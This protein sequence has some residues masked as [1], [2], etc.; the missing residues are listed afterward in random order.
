MIGAIRAVARRLKPA[1][2]VWEGIYAHR[3]D[4]PTHRAEFTAELLDEMVTTTSR[5]LEQWRAGRK[6]LLWH[7]CLAV[8]AGAASAATRRVSVIDFG[9]G[10]GSAFV[11]LISSLPSTVDVDCVVVDSDEI[12]ARG[13][14]LF[15]NDGRIR[16]VTSLTA[17]PAQ[18][19]IIYLN[20]VLPY[21]DDYRQVLRQLA[22]LQPRFMLMARLT[23]G[24]VPTFAS[25][26]LNVPG[27]V[28][29]Y[30]FHNLPELIEILEG[31]GYVL[32]CHAY[33]EHQYDLSNFPATHRVGRLRNVL[34][35]R[36]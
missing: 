5:A 16:F 20:G 36:R 28:F 18:P 13:R 17:A 29:A 25:R 22:A 8:V 2:P 31:A 4:V 32:A 14:E 7:E 24:D 27:R 15:A 9:G 1:A 23:A 26:Q 30:W 19:D 21:I 33:A 3:R 12:A 34:F 6:P 11:Q 35:A 10:P